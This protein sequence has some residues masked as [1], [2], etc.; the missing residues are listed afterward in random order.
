MSVIDTEETVIVN[1]TSY[2]ITMIIDFKCVC[3][4]VCVSV[5]TAFLA[6]IHELNVYR[7]K[8]GRTCLKCYALQTFPDLLDG[9]FFFF[10]GERP[11]SRR[12]GRTAALRLL[13]Q[14]SYEDGGDDYYLLS[15]S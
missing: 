13:V 1:L 12:Y 11:R 5:L 7:H 9:S 15:F 6:G 2:D 3:V 14:P 8:T 10:S 4:C